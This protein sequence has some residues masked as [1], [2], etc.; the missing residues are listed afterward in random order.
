MDVYIT[1]L[2]S[3][4]RLALSQLP[5]RI[6]VMSDAR[7]QSYDIINLGEVKIPKGTA[8]KSFTW[9]GV[10]PGKSRLG[11]SLVKDQ[12]WQS[13]EEI[14][15]IWESWRKK[16]TKL[17]LMVTETVINYDVYLETFIDEPMGGNGDVEYTIYFLE[18]KPME[19][20]TVDEL[21]IKPKASAV[22]KKETRP[23]AKPAPKTHTAKKGDTLWAI[24]QKHLGKGSRYPE[25]HKLNKDKVK[26]P[27]L[28]YPGQV[29]TLPN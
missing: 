6:K 20:Y 1:E 22:A 24:A 3:G 5:E 21:N 23:P 26:D 10:L 4:T 16:E 9:K 29:L 15:G 19:I 27:N 12:H 14:L 8:L 13:P 18:A 2:E 25:I 17:R 28:I 11:T 7:F